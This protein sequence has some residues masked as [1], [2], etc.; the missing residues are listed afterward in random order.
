MIFNLF[1]ASLSS[2]KIRDRT[3]ALSKLEDLSFS[4]SSVINTIDRG[5][6]LLLIDSLGQFIEND[7]IAYEKSMTSQIEVRL[8]KASAV[9]RTVIFHLFTSDKFA[10]QF[11]AKPLE[12]VIRILLNNFTYTPPSSHNGKAI[13]EP[14]IIHIIKSLHDI[15][16]V[17][18]FMD[19]LNSSIHLNVINAILDALKFC[20]CNDGKCSSLSS[21]ENTISELFSILLKFLSPENISYLVV[22]SQNSRDKENLYLQ[23]FHILIDYSDNIFPDTKR[24]RASLVQVFKIINT[25]ML[26]LSTINLKLCHRYA[27]LGLSFILETKNIALYTL[28]A[29]ISIFINISP[30]FLYLEKIP[31]IVG[32]N[33]NIDKKGKLL[34]AKKLS[35]DAN[36]SFTE[37]D[38]VMGS[39]QG[40]DIEIPDSEAEDLDFSANLADS[41]FS[42]KRVRDENDAKSDELERN[43]CK[44]IEIIVDTITG[45]SNPKIYAFPESA[46]F[47][48]LFTLVDKSKYGLFTNRY[49]TLATETYNVGWL[50]RLGLAKII[51]LYYFMKKDT[52]MSLVLGGIELKK[53]R[54][55]NGLKSNQSLL[56]LLN[57]SFNPIDFY[58]SILSNSVT[59]HKKKILFLQSFSMYLSDCSSGS[60]VK[61]SKLNIEYLVEN[62]SKIITQVLNFFEIL[63]SDTIIWI[64][65]SLKVIYNISKEFKLESKPNVDNTSNLDKILK[66]CL[67]FLKNPKLSKWSCNLLASVCHFDLMDLNVCLKLSSSIKKQY[68][69]LIELSEISG[70]AL[71]CKESVMFWT[72]SS[73]VAKNLKF[74][75]VKFQSGITNNDLQLYSHKVLAWIF[76]KENTWGNLNSFSDVISFVQIIF[77]CLDM[78]DMNIS[79]DFFCYDEFYSGNLINID[80]IQKNKLHLSSYT[81]LE[82]IENDFDNKKPCAFSKISHHALIVGEYDSNRMSAK[83]E[84]FFDTL[85]E[86]SINQRA[87]TWILALGVIM[88]EQVHMFGRL[89]SLTRDLEGIFKNEDTGSLH[90]TLIDFL[91]K[92]PT[93][94]DLWWSNAE[95][96]MDIKQILIS[97]LEIV[98]NNSKSFNSE[99]K[100][101]KTSELS[102][103]I[104]SSHVSLKDSNDSIVNLC[105]WK[106]KFGQSVEQKLIYTILVSLFA[107][108]DID[109]ALKA[110]FHFEQPLI[111]NKLIILFSIIELCEKY[112]IQSISIEN[113]ELIIL[114]IVNLLQEPD[115]MRFELMIEMSCKILTRFCQL[116]NVVG[117]N[118]TELIDDA[119]N[120]YQFFKSVHERNMIN[121]ESGTINFFKLNLAIL[122]TIDEQNENFNKSEIYSLVTN[123]FTSMNNFC[124]YQ[125]SPNIV[126]YLKS[127]KKNELQVYSDFTS[128]IDNI[129][130]S[131]E[132]ASLFNVFMG[133]IST[134]SESLLIASLCNVIEFAQ[135]DQVRLYFHYFINKLTT[136]NNIESIQKLFWNMKVIFF[137][138]WVSFNNKISDFPYALF[139]F[140]LKEFYLKNY[141]TM[142]AVVMAFTDG[143][144]IESIAENI[145]MSL[146]D[147]L[148]DSLSLSLALNARNTTKIMDSK[149]K[150]C[151]K[152]LKKNIKEQIVLILFQIICCCDLTSELKVWEFFVDKF[153]N[154]QYPSPFVDNTIDVE[155]LKNYGITNSIRYSLD[156]MTSFMETA[157]KKKWSVS[158]AYLLCEH[159]LLLFENSI[160]LAEKLLNLRRIKL[161]YLLCPEVFG[162]FKISCLIINSL[163]P[164]IGDENLQQDT[165]HIIYCMLKCGG[166]L[167]SECIAFLIQDT[168]IPLLANLMKNLNRDS[169]AMINLLTFVEKCATSEPMQAYSFIMT[170]CVDL[171]QN[172]DVI[173][174]FDLVMKILDCGVEVDRMK[175]IMEVIP[176]FFSLDSSTVNWKIEEN[177]HYLT[178]NF[179]QRLYAIQNKFSDLINES[180]QVWI[181]LCFGKYFEITG[182]CPT[183]EESE[184]DGVIFERYSTALSTSKSGNGSSTA[185]HQTKYMSESKVVDYVFELIIEKL[186][187]TSSFARFCFE[188]IVGVMIEKRKAAHSD[189]NTNVSF[190]K[191]FA[192]FDDYVHP[193]SNYLCSLSISYFETETKQYHRG[194]LKKALNG[195]GTKILKDS[196]TDWASHVTFGIINELSAFGSI[197]TLLATY[198]SSVPDFS[199]ECLCPLVIYLIENERNAASTIARMIKE[200]FD[201]KFEKL[202][203]EAIHLFCQLVL[204]VRVGLKS[205]SEACATVYMYLDKTKIYNAMLY[206]NKPKAALMILEDYYTTTARIEHGSWKNLDTEKFLSKVYKELDEPDLLFGLPIDPELE[207]GLNILKSSGMKWGEIMF[208]NAKFESSLKSNEKFTTINNFSGGLMDMGWTGISNLLSDNYDTDFEDVKD[209]KFANMWKLNQW[210]LPATFEAGSEN[211]VIYNSFKLINDNINDINTVPIKSIQSLVCNHD[212]FLSTKRLTKSA[213]LESWMRSLSLIC[214]IYEI[215]NLSIEQIQSLQLDYEKNTLWFKETNLERY[216]NLL[217]GRQVLLEMIAQ[218]KYYSDN[219]ELNNGWLLFINELHRFNHLA[220]SQNKIQQSINT[221]VRLDSLLKIP[222]IGNNAFIQRVAKF[223]LALAFWS[224]K[225]ETTFPVITLKKLINA[226]NVDELAIS[227]SPLKNNNLSSSYMAAI[228]TKWL[229]SSKQD[230]PANIMSHYIEPAL[231]KIN[232]NL[233]TDLWDICEAYIIFAD[234]CDNQLRSGD[235]DRLIKKHSDTVKRLKHDL[236]T[237]TE[238][239]SKKKQKEESHYLKQEHRKILT[240][241]SAQRTELKVCEAQKLNYIEKAILFHLKAI[242]LDN[243]EQ[244]QN[245]VDRF[246]ALWI[247][248]HDKPF[249]FSQDLLSLPTYKFVSWNYQLTSRL[250]TTDSVFQS[251]LQRLILQITFMHP[252]HTLYMLKSLRVGKYETNDAAAL[253]RGEISSDLWRKLRKRLKYFNVEGYDDVTSY[254]DITCDRILELAKEKRDKR[255]PSKCIS[256][257]RY[258]SGDWWLSTLPTYKLPSPVESLKILKQGKYKA[259]ELLTIQSVCPDVREAD[260]GISHPKIMK[261]VL[262]NGETQRML[263]KHQ[264]DLRQDAIMQQVFGKVNVLLQRDTETKKRK[265][266]I[267][268][269][270]VL[271]LGPQSGVIEFVSNSKP[272]IDILKSLHANSDLSLKSTRHSKSKHQLNVEE[273]EQTWSIDYCRKK[274]RESESIEDKIES[275]KAICSK[276]KPM[277]RFFFFQNYLSPD[278]W[279]ES[280]L[281]YGRG[282]AA[283]SMIGHIMGI[284]DRHCNNILLDRSTGEPIHIDFGVSFDSGKLLPVPELVPFRLTRDL[285]DGLGITGT[286]GLFS[287]GCEHVLKVLRENKQYIMGILD[288]LKYDPLY[289]WTLS[290]LRKRKFEAMFDSEKPML[291]VEQAM[292]LDNYSEACTAIDT[293]LKKLE[294]RALTNEAIVREL[295]RE[296]TDIENLALIFYGWAPFL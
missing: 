164:Y 47:L 148:K 57:N 70:P 68:E 127:L 285:I 213:G 255:N 173:F 96:N 146:N 56:D 9:F 24:E 14:V 176:F 129:Q 43:L 21:N 295:I 32:D 250:S 296:A 106:L 217:I 293:I 46:L 175:S 33:W 247:E 167:N 222:Q 180:M 87:L 242:A 143:E 40:S 142:T 16:S 131:C 186:P 113:F 244:N 50:L 203:P 235:L 15:F 111:S 278:S 153:D 205:N 226:D 69:N 72:I 85:I 183:F 13:F 196:F 243:F 287:K 1:I 147:L 128:L 79:P 232:A 6:L 26:N 188:S 248:Y 102:E 236:A 215:S 36:T 179:I 237:L 265:F 2:T 269:Y 241:L 59:S 71:I 133:E 100:N 258:V 58:L 150:E 119:L 218:Q 202:D 162:H 107:R 135:Y 77:W 163:S 31:K 35:N 263:I 41:Y 141:K 279:I 122:T 86:S 219:T 227:D 78:V 286:D 214:N 115:I 23:I 144:E 251:T 184:F 53:R 289:N 124:K 272:L 149:F 157:N 281:I 28:L 277:L 3:D 181:G 38:V 63:S 29:E 97:C 11:K 45:S 112:D 166:P 201:Q 125:V 260:S 52:S 74:Q 197:F 136:L 170:P 93:E 95:S 151:K 18:Y 22:F 140:G 165:S 92:I 233:D 152:Y 199:K 231:E 257:N 280:R 37:S 60:Y 49:F 275:Y 90:T 228:L 193:L 7:K 120:I 121:S 34:P 234:F 259:N 207:Y 10:T 245:N 123:S 130:T 223:N 209:M 84:M 98:S 105:N 99:L 145:N 91:I 155:F 61:S 171:L 221:A 67:E 8:N 27:K 282:L 80:A 154:S 44:S 198:I 283:S 262:S 168:W 254:I 256:L 103:L 291:Q 54:M 220:T 62:N 4:S 274:M 65:L 208:E 108:G 156:L 138:Q 270:N 200:F 82:K 210:D 51:G 225:S 290:P 159:I 73:K 48:H 89:F 266:R 132:S 240:R 158:L 42:N 88:K 66:F 17:Q 30:S 117:I 294:G 212:E 64:L 110:V 224:E 177:K 25:S 174:N 104:S 288:V 109:S 19:V 39:S 276:F 239:T 172:R 76:S 192:S 94:N 12:K 20:T 182:K 195:F 160:L 118:N 253:S 206:I 185:E 161:I 211:E 178:V 194:D 246:C 264:D 271:P 116:W 5:T 101:K 83:L 191:L 55:N 81:I 252:F 261:V 238:I 204:L 114:S 169:R 268:T 139:G 187:L 230:T 134:A 216:E 249:D 190:N 284:G 137:R 292:K 126:L 75:N 229:N 267:R 189:I 273:E